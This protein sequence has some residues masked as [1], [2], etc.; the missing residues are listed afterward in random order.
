MATPDS[1]EK[2]RCTM[3]ACLRVYHY[4][5]P[6]KAG[7]MAVDWYVSQHRQD[8]GTTT[9][10]QMKCRVNLFPLPHQPGDP[11]SRNPGRSTQTGMPALW[12]LVHAQGSPNLLFSQVYQ[13]LLRAY[14]TTE[15]YCSRN[16]KHVQCGGSK[17]STG[18]CYIK[19]GVSF[20]KHTRL[21][22]Y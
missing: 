3:Q 18:L 10:L 14:F 11:Q 15:I 19:I 9:K 1:T 21:N 22:N 20:T 12:S 2:S 7:R 8:A 16:V 13:G 6:A 4:F 17:S 5:S